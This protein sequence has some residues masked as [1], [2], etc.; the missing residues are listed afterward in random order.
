MDRRNFIKAGALL[1]IPGVAPAQVSSSLLSATPSEVEG[2]FYP[3]LAQKDRDFDL[4][5]IQGNKESAKGSKIFIIGDV[6]DTQGKPLEDATVDIWQ[7]NSFGRYRHPHDPNKAP[8]DENFQGWAIVQTG[9]AGSFRF[10]TILPGAYPATAN[11]VR[12]PHIH[13]K[14]SKRGYPE[15]ITQMY[16]PEMELN[17]KDR[18]LLS[19]RPE[20]RELMIA[21]KL[22]SKI[23][24]MPA[25]Q[26]RIVLQQA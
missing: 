17:S 16:F 11:W 21:K 2:P 4:T 24:G 26:Y 19:K 23:D 14:V 3:V 5:Q 18:L 22:E 10:K 15:L 12:P 7:A 6:V 1:G 9:E 20:Q 25:Y 13:F 8:L